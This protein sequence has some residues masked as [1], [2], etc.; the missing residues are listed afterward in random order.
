VCVGGGGGGGPIS[1]VNIVEGGSDRGFDFETF[2]VESGL[3]F[4]H[5]IPPEPGKINESND[6]FLPL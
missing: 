1:G 5:S 4:L 3:K 2:R 6:P